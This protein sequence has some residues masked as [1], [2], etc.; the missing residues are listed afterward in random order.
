MIWRRTLFSDSLLLWDRGHTVT[1]VR[2]LPL[3]HNLNSLNFEVSSPI[4]PLCNIWNFAFS[5]EFIRWTKQFVPI[6]LRRKIEL[7]AL[8]SLIY[9]FI[10]LLPDHRFSS[11]KPKGFSMFIRSLYVHIYIYICTCGYISTYTTS[12][13]LFLMVPTSTHEGEKGSGFSFFHLIPWRYVALVSWMTDSISCSRLL[14]Q[15]LLFIGS[16]HVL[17]QNFADAAHQQWKQPL[18]H[19]TVVQRKFAEP[20]RSVKWHLWRRWLH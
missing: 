20:V 2:I 19:L 6:L 16:I 13:H 8:T 10:L 4:N 17:T 11:V 3:D 12:G 15:L 5:R 9:Y 1:Q 18:N 7:G 14:M